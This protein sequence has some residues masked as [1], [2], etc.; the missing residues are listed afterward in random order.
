MSESSPTPHHPD[1]HPT[2]PPTV[3]APQSTENGA[4]LVYRSHEEALA[5]AT[6]VGASTGGRRRFGPYEILEEIGRGGMGIVFKARQPA[7]DRIVA[8]KVIVPGNLSAED[9]LVRFRT[10]VEATARVHHPNIVQI[11][12][13]GEHAGQHFYSMEF[14]DGPSLARK[15]EPGPLPG[16]Q[17]ARYVATIARAIHHAHANGILHRDLK[18][19]N[20]LLDGEDQPHVTDFGLAKKLGCDS[21]QTRTGA[22]LG[23]PSYMAPEQAAGRTRELGPACDVYGLGAVLYELLTGRPPFRSDTPLD[24]LLHVLDRDPAPPRLLNPKVENDLET[25]CLKCLEKDPK[26]RY[27]SA[28]ALADDLT[29]YLNGE[30]ISARSF[31]V[32][33]RLTRT[34]DRSQ[35]DIEFGSWGWMMM[36]FGAIVAVSHVLIDVLIRTNQSGWVIGTSRGVPLVLMALV[37]WRYRRSRL[38]PSSQA[39]RQLWTIWI[40]YL[41]ACAVM[42]LLHRRLLAHDVIARGPGGPEH[43]HELILYPTQCILSGLAFFV[44]GSCYWGR[45]YAIGVAFFALAFLMIFE[46]SWAPIAFGLV[47]AG[48][49][50]TIG[51]HLLR[52]G[53][54]AVHS[55]K[56]STPGS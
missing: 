39:E 36:A 54:E 38:L 47:W 6:E 34:L 25:I 16:R 48:A 33:D 9:E 24:T 1:E 17:A 19:G 4:T 41:V 40:G 31:N 5:S 55:S 8:L 2:L 44:M 20:V 49:F 23:T 52:L 51:L 43:W 45:C 42:A 56:D 37:F 46:L 21:S 53:A 26:R 30:S 12:E 18:P 50:A 7:L 32:I 13:V 22:V 15:L 28:Q 14:I 27:A 3:A 10:E 35:Y 11:H 29:R